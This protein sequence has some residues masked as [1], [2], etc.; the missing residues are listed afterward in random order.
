MTG[1]ALVRKWCV[2]ERVT[3]S[4]DLADRLGVRPET[5]CRWERADGRK[6]LGLLRRALARLLEEA[7]EGP[8][9]FEAPDDPD[10]AIEA[11]VAALSRDHQPDCGYGETGRGWRL[12]RRGEVVR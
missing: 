4:M 2:D 7:R 10:S 9:S 5:V 11:W 12:I 6:P 1:S 8:D 3:V